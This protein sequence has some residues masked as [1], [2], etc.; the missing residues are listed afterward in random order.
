MNA[1]RLRLRASLALLVLAA[2]GGEA[3]PR[4]PVATLTATSTA[5]ATA[6]VDPG[7]SVSFEAPAGPGSSRTIT[8]TGRVFGAGAKAV[9][10]AH[11]FPADQRSWFPFARELAARGVM[12]LTFDFRGYGRSEGAKEI[13]RIS[14]DLE[15]AVAEARRQGAEVVA[16]AGAS[17]GGTAAIMVAAK[18]PLAAVVAISAPEEF[19]GLDARADVRRLRV[20]ALF[21][22]AENDPGGA[23]ASAR[24]LYDATPGPKRLEI[25]PAAAAHGTNLLSDPV[26]GPSERLSIESFLLDSLEAAG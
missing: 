1:A 13:S 23:A 8:L 24:A 14:L 9:V 11:M 20:P 6:S 2:C 7:R 3:G 16:V 22:A 17:M 25:V 10:L 26:A 21:V 18:V 5:T 19:R 15:A 12:A 4:P